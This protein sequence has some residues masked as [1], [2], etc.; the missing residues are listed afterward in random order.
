MALHSLLHAFLKSIAL[1]IIIGALLVYFLMNT[2]FAQGIVSEENK[3]NVRNSEVLYNI[4]STEKWHISGD[5]IYNGHECKKIWYY[6]WQKDLPYTFSGLLRED[7]NIVYYIPP[8]DQEGIL[9]N[10]NLLPGDTCQIINW[11]A[12]EFSIIVTGMD[13]I[14]TFYGIQRKRWFLNNS[15]YN[16]WIEGIGSNNGPLHTNME[17]QCS[18]WFDWS[19]LCFY[20]SDSLLYKWSE[21][22]DCTATSVN[23][24]KCD[25]AENIKIYPIPV[26]DKFEVR[27]A[28]FEVECVEIYNVGGQKIFAKE[29]PGST[30]IEIDACNFNT[31]MYVCRI[32]FSD[33]TVIRKLVKY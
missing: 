9:Y 8:G 7:S 22:G 27:S 32:M 33:R 24:D 6:L 14:E 3:W 17:S 5:S 16:Y 29:Y 4:I 19:L 25:H 15:P 21:T 23:I 31:G 30:N 26:Q 18:D 20:H 11:C 28:E 12:S 13:T 10:F 1:S 2:V